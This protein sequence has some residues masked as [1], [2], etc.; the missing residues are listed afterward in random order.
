MGTLGGMSYI[1]HIHIECTR[2]EDWTGSDDLDFY[3]DQ[4]YVGRVTISSGET[5]DVDGSTMLFQHGFVDA[6]NTIYV[7]EDDFDPDDLVL[8]HYVTQTDISNG[9]HTKN[10]S[11]NCDYS[12]QFTF[13][14]F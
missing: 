10:T 4:T 12:F 11:G 3:V 1:E 14:E 13:V 6:G 7:Y 5:K 9:L 2:Q 8:S